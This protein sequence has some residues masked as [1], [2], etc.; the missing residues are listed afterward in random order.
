MLSL[1]TGSAPGAKYAVDFQGFL[2]MTL[3]PLS[4]P[5]LYDELFNRKD[6]LAWTTTVS[7]YDNPYLSPKG[8]EEL[9][10]SLTEDEEEARLY[11]KF[12]HLAGRVYKNFDE[13]IHV[14][15]E[16]RLPKKRNW[17][18]WFV[19]DPADRRP[20][21]AIWFT[22]DPFN[23]I[24]VF[25]E[26]V[27]KGTIKETSKEIIKREVM[28]GVNPM[29]VIRILDP[30]K[31]ET[32]SAVSGLKLKEEFASHA[33]YF[34]TDVNDD[35]TLGHLAVS[36]RLSYDKSEPISTTNCPRLYFIKGKTKETVRQIL[37]YVWDDHKGASKASKSEKEQ[38]KDIN[39]D[40]PD[41]LRY[42][43]VFNPMFYVPGD[44]K[45]PYDDSVSGDVWS[46]FR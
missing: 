43:I 19:L 12:R 34:T 21:H 14:I 1:A 20:H 36:E 32:P 26:L 37:S 2:W 13:D 6:E 24:Y 25:D 15:P 17:P 46:F 29:Q 44:E 7:I 16:E 45:D 8:I 38:P 18:V 3:T 39:K 42:G 10:A 28:M 23:K 40:L 33:V 27:Y 31:G 30:N 41:C 22:V 35:L 4:E 9:K 5:W 11:G